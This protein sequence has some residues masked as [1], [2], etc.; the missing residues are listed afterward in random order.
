MIRNSTPGH[1]FE[2]MKT[3]LRRYTYSNVH[4]RLL[5]I[6]KT[7]KQLK[8]PLTEEWI[9]RMWCIYMQ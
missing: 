9:K 3:N 1:I 7:P 2:T 6:A 8:C 5:T 4:S